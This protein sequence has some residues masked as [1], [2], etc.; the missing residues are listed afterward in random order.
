VQRWE[1]FAVTAGGAA[2]ALTGLLFVAVSIRI[3]VISAS[4]ELR[5]RAAQTLV[6]FATVLFVALLLTIPGQ[7]RRELGG[8]ML[9]LALCT[10]ALLVLLD[11]RAERGGEGRGPVRTAARMLDAVAP[12]T[13]TAALLACCS[14]LLLFGLQA[15]LDL[16][17]LPVLVA[18]AGGLVS[19]W[20]LLT[21]VPA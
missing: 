16:L 3:E 2:A 13:V 11:R 1:T 10:A 4:Q 15:G 18:L 14:V 12:N 20:L 9:A 21:K 5:N 7:G 6:L 19:A 8:E 17:V